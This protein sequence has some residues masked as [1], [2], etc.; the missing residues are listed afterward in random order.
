MTEKKLKWESRLRIGIAVARA[1]AETHSRRLDTKPK[2]TSEIH[3]DGFSD[4]L[5]LQENIVA[6][7]IVVPT[8]GYRPPESDYTSEASDVYA[9]GILLLELLTGAF[10]V[11]D[12]RMNMVRSVTRKFLEL[13]TLLV[14]EFVPVKNHTA[15]IQM[16]KMLLVAILCV[17]ED[18]MQRPRSSD[19]V[20]MMEGIKRS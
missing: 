8:A 1:I 11:N 2:H 7:S 3:R 12:D 6:S 19:V 18:P 13:G 14:F 10:P 15:L 20:K 16:W 9:F 5:G 17:D 4:D